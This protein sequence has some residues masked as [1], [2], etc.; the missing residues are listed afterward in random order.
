MESYLYKFVDDLISA[1][2][3]QQ[4]TGLTN[5]DSMDPELLQDYGV[6]KLQ[7]TTQGSPNE[8]WTYLDGPTISNG[9]AVYKHKPIDLEEAK[10]IARTKIIT[11]SSQHC[12]AE[13]EA[14]GLDPLL[15]PSLKS[16]GALSTL[17]THLDEVAAALETKLDALDAAK[18]T[19]EVLTL[20]DV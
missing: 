5:V 1:E 9:K 19:K 10:S 8:P 12:K 16:D 18:S 11:E 7:V 17:K 13:C 14:L 15:V 2:S 3:L 4:K 6:T 20:L